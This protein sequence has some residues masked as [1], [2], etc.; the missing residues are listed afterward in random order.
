MNNF[1]KN[2][3][4][5]LT[6]VV[7]FWFHKIYIYIQHNPNDFITIGAAI[8]GA[9]VGAIATNY[10]LTRQ[11]NKQD[12][13]ARTVNL[14]DE[15]ESTERAKSRVR[16]SKF[17][18]NLHQEGKDYDYFAI[19]EYDEHFDDLH[20]LL[21]FF[22][23]VSILYAL[24]HLDKKLINKSLAYPLKQYYS[25]FIRKLIL[26]TRK[27]YKGNRDKDIDKVRWVKSLIYLEKK[28]KIDKYKL[29]MEENKRN[30]YYLSN[31]FRKFSSKDDNAI[32]Q[33]ELNKMIKW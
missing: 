33:R 13:I 26:D 17:F 3:D 12:R 8:V 29:N 23:R 22:E 1:F 20:I 11:Q 7:D 6:I 15:F 25:K 30:N 2:V 18:S 19:R 14:Y 31:V 27:I 9:L 4:D 16:L 28:V 10:F 24:D 21:H 5:A 32:M